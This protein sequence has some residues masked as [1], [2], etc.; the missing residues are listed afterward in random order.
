MKPERIEFVKTHKKPIIY[1]MTAKK[2]ESFAVCLHCGQGV[3]NK[4]AEDVAVFFECHGR[5]DCLSHWDDYAPLYEASAKIHRVVK[6]KPIVQLVHALPASETNTIQTDSGSVKSCSS[7]NSESKNILTED[8]VSDLQIW[9]EAHNYDDLE[10]KMQLVKLIETAD[11]QRDRL[12]EIEEMLLSY[13]DSIGH[14]SSDIK[15]LL[16]HLIA[17]ALPT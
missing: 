8:S 12:D 11:D 1:Q 10:P 9:A 7:S 14:A 6:P 16:A 13:R 3:Y 4:S 5:A 15:T 2:G 17:S